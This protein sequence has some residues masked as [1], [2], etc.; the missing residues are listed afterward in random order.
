MATVTL[1]TVN[2]LLKEIYEDRLRDQLNSEVTIL[3]RIEKT[4]EGVTNEVGGKYVT[5]PIRVQRNQGMGAR[6]E[7]E[8]LPVARPPKYAAARVTLAYLYGTLQLTGQAISLADSNP[9]AFVSVMD[10]NIKDLKEGLAKDMSRQIFGTSAGILATANSAGS[11]TTFVCLNEEAIYLEVGM[12]VD[13]WDTS[14]AGLMTGG[15][16]EITA[17]APG[18]TNTTVTYTGASGAATASGDTLHRNGS[19]NKETIGFRQI[20][21]SS[22]T[23]YNVDPT[24]YPVWKSTVNNNSGTNRA[25][26]E[27]LMIKLADDIRKAGGGTPTLMVSNLGV[28]RAYFNLLVQQRRNV[29]TQNFTGGFKGLAFTT[30][31][32]EIPFIDD[33]DAQTNRIYFINEKEIKLYR[34]GDWSFMDRDGSMWQRV[35][36]STGTYD[37]YQAIMFKYCQLGTHRRNAHG[38][39]SD[40]TEG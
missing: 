10:E 35:I 5:F 28:K 38:V 6:N 12:F 31:K 36:D 17:I 26:S 20:V 4:S 15:P 24:V 30:T 14:A 18:A 23:L 40:I 16:F 21:D 8:A 29:N 33:L 7:N 19:R 2:E 22:G 32:G 39:L 27:G 1:T 37:A 25:L 34:E 9:Q 3:S 13:I 11:T